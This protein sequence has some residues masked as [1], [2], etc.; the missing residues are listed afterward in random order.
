MDTDPRTSRNNKALIAGALAGAALAG[1][2]E[3]RAMFRA[4][5]VLAGDVGL[6][7]EWV[8]QLH[9][10]ADDA[11]PLDSGLREPVL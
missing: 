5:A 7:H 8:E 11:P 10:W 9:R 4:A 3:P 1:V 2:P 6:N